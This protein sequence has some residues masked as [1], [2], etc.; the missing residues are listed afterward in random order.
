[1][2][3]PL[4]VAGSILHRDIKLQNIFVSKNKTLKLGDFGISRHVPPMLQWNRMQSVQVAAIG[5]LRSCARN[6]QPDGR[7]RGL[8]QPGCVTAAASRVEWLNPL[9]VQRATAKCTVRTEQ[10]DAAQR[11]GGRNRSLRVLTV[12]TVVSRTR[13]PSSACSLFADRL[14]TDGLLSHRKASLGGSAGATPQTC[15]AGHCALAAS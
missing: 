1:M 10:W 4:C 8:P 2:S 5:W 6:E 7:L 15:L 3:P 13:L 14:L 11:C 12:L 9:R